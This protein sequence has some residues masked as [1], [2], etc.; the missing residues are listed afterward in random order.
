MKD[1]SN[2]YDSAWKDVIEK[3]FP[4]FMEYFYAEAFN[5]IDWSKKVTFLDKELNRIFKD[6]EVGK[7]RVDELVQVFL[8]DGSEKWLYI[9][10]EV[11]G[12]KDTDFLERMYIYNY[13]IFDKYKHEV[14]SFGILSDNDPDYKPFK[15]ETGRW[16]F[17]LRMDVPLIKLLDYANKTDELEKSDNPM[18]MVVLA[19][20][21]NQKAKDA[22]ER[23]NIKLSLIRKLYTKGFDKSRALSV[24]KFI[25]WVITLPAIYEE[26][27]KQEVDK[28]E[29]ETMAYVTSFERLAKKE[30]KV[31]D[32]LNMLQDGIPVEKVAKYTGLSIEEIK[33]LKVPQKV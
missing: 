2:D 20:I 13:R 23:Y 33:E 19:S 12:Y 25:D 16:G 29:V 24:L 30:G 11:Q 28:M 15:Y 31:E 3:I 1:I 18:A 9:H 21:E 10:I 17:K 7:K 4:D 27:L 22:G 5:D 14:I 32:A 26:K 6:H 8:K